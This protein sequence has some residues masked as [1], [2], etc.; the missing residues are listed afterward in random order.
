MLLA[1][2][3]SATSQPLP[4]IPSKLAVEL[5]DTHGAHSRWKVGSVTLVLPD[6]WKNTST[7]AVAS[8][9]GP[10]GAIAS[11][12]A[13]EATNEAIGTGYSLLNDPARG[14]DAYR[15]LVDWS[16]CAGTSGRQVQTAELVGGTAVMA[17]C[18]VALGR[19]GSAMSRSL[20][21]RD[22]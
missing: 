10:R 20:L 19:A 13:V 8:L 22:R 17:V 15:R 9:V 12:A 2:V 4:L 21:N 3:Q 18:P 5:I 7:A 6:S 1:A 11:F 14:P 16:E